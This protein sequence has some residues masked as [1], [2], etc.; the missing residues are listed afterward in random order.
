MPR[1]PP[2]QRSS[3]RRCGPPR[4][5]RA[6][7]N[8]RRT[9]DR[10]EL[11]EALSGVSLIEAPSAQDEA[12]TV[13]LILRE[14]IETPGR[15]AALVSPDRL[16]AR[17]V[18]IRLEAWGIRV[19]DSA[20]RPFA[21]TVPGAFLALVI[22]ARRQRFRTRRDDGAAPPSAVPG[23][24]Q[25][26]RYSPLCARARDQRISHGL[27]S[28]AASKASSPRSIPRSAIDD[29]ERSS[30]TSRRSVSGKKTATARVLSCSRL[31]KLSS[32]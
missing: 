29:A 2:A 17:R 6:G 8:S 11:G 31:Q 7:T 12:E 19:D 10:A 27:I 13:A 1:A 18:A 26:V 20:G 23:R 4:R 16:L 3:A 24:S 22:N 5:R 25:D 15:T 9:A 28:V 30:R 32:R 14:A 21:K